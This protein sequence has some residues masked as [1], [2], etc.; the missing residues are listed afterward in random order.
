MAI[1]KVYT[2][3][4]RRLIS[5]L[6]PTLSSLDPTLSS[7]DPTL[8][9]PELIFSSVPLE[10]LP[11]GFLLGLINFKSWLLWPIYLLQFFVPHKVGLGLVKYLTEGGLNDP[12]KISEHSKRRP[13]L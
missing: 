12:K 9:S 13:P 2:S 3:E 11:S 7:P 8:S 6:D 10:L 1:V 5:S 4:S